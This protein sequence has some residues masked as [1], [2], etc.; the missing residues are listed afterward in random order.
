[1]TEFAGRRIWLLF[2]G[3]K[4]SLGELFEMRVSTIC[5]VGNSYGLLRNVLASC[6]DAGCLDVSLPLYELDSGNTLTI[7]SQKQR[8]FR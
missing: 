8:R 5:S 7:N 4:G 1:M 3:P 2:G 6:R